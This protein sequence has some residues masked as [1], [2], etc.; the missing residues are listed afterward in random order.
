MEIKILP[1][2]LSNLMARHRKPALLRFKE[3]GRW[4]DIATAEVDRRVRAACMGLRDA[5]LERGDRVGLL[6]ENR[7]EWCLADLAIQS[8]GAANVP[9]YPTLLEEQIRHILADCG[10]RAV[11]CSTPEQVA[12]ILAIRGDLP[13]LETILVFDP[14]PGGAPEGVSSW[15]SLRE[16]GGRAAGRRPHLFEDLRDAV[17]PE[18]LASIIYTSGTTGLPKGVPLSHDNFLSNVRSVVSLVPI[19]EDDVALSFL[20]LSHVLER[21]VEYVYL[22]RGATIAYAESIE[23]VPQNLQEVRPTVAVAVPRV[24]EKFYARVMETVNGGPRLRKQIFFWGLNVGKRQIPYLLE[25]HPLPGALGFQAAIA[26]RLVFQKLRARVGGKLRYFI[27]GG[28]PLNPRL[29]EFFWSVGLPVYEGYGLT[30]TS[31]VIAVNHPGMVKLGTVG[32]VIP[33][34]KVRIAED[35]EILVQG[36]NVMSGYYKNED[37]NR[38]AFRDGWFCTGDIGRLDDQGFLTITD[39]KKDVLK[40]SG[41]K[42]IA[43]QPMENDLKAN[44]YIANAVV[45]GDR[46]KYIA[47]LLV[48]NLDNL[49]AYCRRHGLGKLPL[50]EK[51]RHEKVLQL[52]RWQ[53]D[54]V[55]KGRPRYE[56]IKTFRLLPRDFSL[57]AGEITPT[58]KVKRNV[59]E[60]NYREEI[61]ALYPDE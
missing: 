34:V 5:G 58:L 9:L 51:L 2:L 45:L 59:V 15:S 19:T 26:D 44:K 24:F 7:P 12:K 40:T 41:G 47:A 52:Y 39:R 25:G 31:P 32:P 22:A 6:S 29:A 54:R 10:A 57:E 4:R 55:M 50:E 61:G 43:P 3:G 13:D 33:G 56:Q 37:A 14:P 1:D 16:A 8:L 49:E 30:E 38:Q 27:S 28:A 46:R 21:M 42:M 18:D 23:A 53:V 17:R 20:P 35:G 11:I 48:P 60:S 36:P